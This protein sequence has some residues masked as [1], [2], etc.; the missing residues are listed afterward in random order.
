[1]MERTDWTTF[2]TNAINRAT[3]K[4]AEI[5]PSAPLPAK[6]YGTEPPIITADVDPDYCGFLVKSPRVKSVDEITHKR[7]QRRWLAS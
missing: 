5:I 6:K 4:K 3:C 1:M 7:W 2:L